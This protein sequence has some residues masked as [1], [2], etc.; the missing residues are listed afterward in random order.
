VGAQS[1]LIA[2]I[3]VIARDRKGK[4]YR[5]GAETRRTA[6]VERSE[7]QRGAPQHTVIPGDGLH[8]PFGILVEG[9]GGEGCSGIILPPANLN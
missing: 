8:K 4:T 6:E 7:Y 3:A 9:E 2:D 1:A 5:E